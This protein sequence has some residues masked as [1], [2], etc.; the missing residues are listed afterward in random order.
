MDTLTYSPKVEAYAAVTN[1]DSTEYYDLTK[2]ITS[3]SVVRN[4]DAAS[5]FTI[6]LQNKNG[7]Y[8]NVFTP[9]DRI[10]IFATGADGKRYQQL[11]GYIKKVP[12]F[13]L[14][15]QDFAMEGRCPIYRLQEL[16]WDPDLALSQ[17]LL[18]M[19][20]TD[21][22]W[23]KVIKRLL[24]EVAGMSEDQIYVGDVPAEVINWAYQLYAA[25]K[26]DIADT[27]AL[28][29]DFYNIIKTSSPA[30]ASGGDSSSSGDSAANGTLGEGETITVPDSLA[31]TG[32]IGDC[33]YI[34][35]PSSSGFWVGDCLKVYNKWASAGKKWFSKIATL[36]GRYL[37][38]MR[39]RFGSVGD[40]VDVLLEDGTVMNCTM[41]DTKGSDAAEWGHDYGSGYSLVEFEAEV[42]FKTA[43]V[44][45][46][47]RGKKVKSVTNC[48]SIL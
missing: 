36:D 18:G 15:N 45:S 38:A 46:N 21:S 9:M 35:S 10:V 42:G 6:K 11:T 30:F 37:I 40:K 2:D 23:D 12:K 4:I 47:W 13:I 29:E 48:G 14:F 17:Q 32:I 1:G 22:N 26:S 25:Q 34:E 44:P 41:L 33:T 39:P 19:S 27:K 3:C 8:N 5:S 20:D 7:K 28:V 31:Q 24:V 16:W 43:D